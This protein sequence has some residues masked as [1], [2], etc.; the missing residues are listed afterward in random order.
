M[1]DLLNKLKHITH[2]IKF[3]KGSSFA[4]SP[5]NRT[6]T[7]P[8]KTTGSEVEAWSLL[9][10]IGHALS[11]HTTYE[12]DVDLLLIEVEAWEKAKEIGLKLD[13]SIDED[14][15]QNCL[16]TYRDWLHQRSTCPRCGIVAMQTDSKTYRCH[17][18][19]N[20]W[21]VSASRFCRPYRRSAKTKNP[22]TKPKTPLATFS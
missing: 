6:I 19:H 9:H 3:S 17:N 15:V 13:I 7:Y 5:T 18:C 11:A 21:L 4:W 22:P 2:D 12:S 14:H 10:E 8:S 1:D 16:D 20:T